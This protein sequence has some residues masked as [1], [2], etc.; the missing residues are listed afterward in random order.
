MSSVIKSDVLVDLVQCLEH[1]CFP[2]QSVCGL[3]QRTKHHA[4]KTVIRSELGT[5][6]ISNFY[7]QCHI[8]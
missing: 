1:S 4:Y 7:I 2:V 6:S 8:C 3:A 5:L